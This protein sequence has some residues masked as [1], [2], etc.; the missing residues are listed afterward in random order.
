M[1]TYNYV[2]NYMFENSVRTRRH[3]F[4]NEHTHKNIHGQMGERSRKY[5]HKKHTQMKHKSIEKTSHQK[6]TCTPTHKQ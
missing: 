4:R 2:F 1:D 5:T 6:L 3:E